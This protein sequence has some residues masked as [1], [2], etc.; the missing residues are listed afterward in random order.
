M[1]LAA[2]GLPAVISGA[3]IALLMRSRLAR[4]LLDRPNERSLHRVPTL[5]IGGIGVMAAALPWAFWQADRSM[6]LV[7]ACA[8]ALALLSLADDLR[9][10]P[11]GVRLAAHLAAAA[12]V[13]SQ[14]GMPL[15]PAAIVVVAIAW[16]T[17]LFNFMDGADGL[18][19]GMGAIGFAAYAIAAGFAAQPALAIAAAALASACAGFLAFN[20][21]P[22]RVF[23][24]DAGSVPLGFLAGALGLYGWSR[25]AWAPWFP[26]IAFAPFVVDATI[27]LLRR[28]AAGER[29][30]HAHRGH[31]YQRLVLS[32]WSTRR[33]AL[34][35]YALMLASAG[36]ALAARAASL[37]LQCGIISAAAL[38]YALLIV[39]IEVRLPRAGAASSPRN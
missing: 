18:A 31:Y 30:W 7:L 3:L 2:I 1:L 20:F 24:G 12:L 19:G 9:S 27:T 15:A 23:L 37:M 39:V 14:A 4:H 36:A 17:N 10:L 38:L 22:A 6:A 25:G 11:A 33:L 26:C 29:P 8:A 13:V 21:P 5:R 16:M 28:T 32:G 34:T 35:E